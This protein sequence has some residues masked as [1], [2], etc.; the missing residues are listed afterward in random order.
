MHKSAH[1]EMPGARQ[2]M[3]TE[4]LFHL[5]CI[6]QDGADTGIGGAA[7]A[8]V[9]EVA[10][11]VCGGDA[12]FF[13]KT[14]GMLEIGSGADG[15]FER[16][17]LLVAT[18]AAVEGRVSGHPSGLE[19]PGG[20]G[21]ALPAAY[22]FAL[23]VDELQ[24]AMD[25][26][27]RGVGS[28]MRGYVGQHM[29]IVVVIVRIQEADNLAGSHGDALV[30]GVIDAIVLLGNPAHAALV[31]FRI[32]TDDFHGI[33]SAATVHN[34]VLHISMHLA[35]HAFEGVAYGGGAVEAGCDDGDFHGSV[36]FCEFQAVCQRGKPVVALGIGGNLLVVG[37]IAE[38]LVD[39][40][41]AL[42]EQHEPPAAARKHEHALAMQGCNPADKLGGV[43][44]LC[45][46]RPEGAAFLV[47][48]HELHKLHEV[49]D[50]EHGAL[51]AH[52]GE[53]GQLA[54]QG[55]ELGEVALAAFAVDHGRAENDDTEGRILE[56]AQADFRLHFAVAIEIGGGDG[57]VAGDVFALADGGAVAIHDGAAHEDELR[58]ALGLGLG[59]GFDGKLGVDFVVEGLAL[60]AHVPGIGM[61]DAGNMVHGIVPGEAVI[62]PAAVNHVECCDFILLRPLREVFLKGCA[63]VA[64]CAGDEDFLHGLMMQPELLI[65]DLH[66]T[67]EQG[68][69]SYSVSI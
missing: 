42:A 69:S 2:V 9:D 20:E 21:A 67:R 32:L 29:V 58:H 25:S 65:M 33:I 61:G 56:L 14:E 8:H 23:L 53:H 38:G 15:G 22:D 62:A 59:G 24:V 13:D 47:V 3:H 39:Q 63:Y 30:H 57:G 40:P 50:V 36:C 28:E 1:S 34:D 12:V 54:R 11:D 5:L 45:I 49:A 19:K 48:D 68:G 44:V 31:F 66:D 26:I 37:E 43:A 6:T 60:L 16:A 35:Q 4:G 10:R 55:G 46:L 17:V 51:V 7:G 41:G 18:A 52:R 27:A 64:V